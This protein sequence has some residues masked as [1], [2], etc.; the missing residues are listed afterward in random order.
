MP[1]FLPPTSHHAA[2]SSFFLLPLYYFG[3]VLENGVWDS[4]VCQLCVS[5]RKSSSSVRPIHHLQQQMAVMPSIK[6]PKERAGLRNKAVGPE[7]RG[8]LRIRE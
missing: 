8:L 1:A 5:P 4:D 6:C 2:T 7:V 3:H